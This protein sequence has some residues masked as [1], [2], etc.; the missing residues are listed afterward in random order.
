MNHT[1]FRIAIVIALVVLV[2]VGFLIQ[3]GCVDSTPSK[4][5]TYTITLPNGETFENMTSKYNTPK[6]HFMFPDGRTL[7]VS[8]NYQAISN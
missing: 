8:G 5:K 1:D 3:T 4:P 6:Q 2:V 7:I